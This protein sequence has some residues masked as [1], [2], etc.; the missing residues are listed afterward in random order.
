MSNNSGISITGGGLYANVVAVNGD[1]TNN[2]TATLNIN[3]LTQTIEELWRAIPPQHAAAVAPAMSGLEA[4]ARTAEP[5]KVKSTLQCVIDA[6]K[7]A[8]VAVGAVTALAGPVAK[9]AAMIG[10]SI[11]FF[12]L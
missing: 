5:E 6:L 3:E 11:G 8:G 10:T 12:G 1:A 9:I 4:A 7:S 2:A